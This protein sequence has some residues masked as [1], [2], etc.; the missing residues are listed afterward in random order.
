MCVCIYYDRVEWDVT[1]NICKIRW[2]KV[3]AR[4]HTILTTGS[5]I[6][7]GKKEQNEFGKDV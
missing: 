2:S 7:W 5:D 4:F 1:M 6:V 3:I